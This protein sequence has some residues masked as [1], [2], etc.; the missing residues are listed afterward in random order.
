PDDQLSLAIGRRGQNVRLAS[1]L[2]GWDIDI[3]T[4]G[5]ESDRRGEEFRNRSQMFI[6]SLDIDEVIAH[7]LVTEGFSSVEEVA[8]V[9]LE[10]LA[11]IEGFEQELSEEL[12]SRAQSWLEERDR[13]LSEKVQEL[14]MA[15]D[16]TSLAGLTPAMLV[17]LGENGILTRDDL[18]D[19]ASDEL[20]ELLDG[21]ALSEDEANTIIMAARAHWFA[22]EEG[23]EEATADEEKTEPDGLG[24]EASEPAAV[25]ET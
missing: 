11:A 7:L 5:E 6:D 18:A 17:K 16:L 23:P 3:L 1:Q 9:P 4:E 8:F 14:G 15:E 22:E 25:E 13:K 20:I 10:E 2:T 24:S 21:D 12:R 19:L